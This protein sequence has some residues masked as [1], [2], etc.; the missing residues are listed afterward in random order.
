MFKSNLPHLNKSSLMT[1][2]TIFSR[3]LTGDIPCNEV[4]S[5]EKCLAFKDVE[6]Q[7]PVHILVIPRRAIE[8]L[9]KVT[10][11]DSNLL[12]HLLIVASKVAQQQ[13]L[14]NWRTVI[15]TGAEA[16]QSVFH[17]HLHV[18]GGRELKWPPG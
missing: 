14:T 7:A 10:S 16:G 8:S 4:Y 18:I 9:L 1:G 13:G 12:G 6:P 15:N 3:I 11:D 5:D 2:E 17:L